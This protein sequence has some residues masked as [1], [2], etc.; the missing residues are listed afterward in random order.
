MDAAEQLLAQLTAEQRDKLLLAA[1]RRD[2]RVAAEAAAAV[3][4]GPPHLQLEST[5]AAFAE[6]PAP[7]LELIACYVIAATATSTST[8]PPPVGAAL[9]AARSLRGTCRAWRRSIETARTVTALDLGPTEAGALWWDP[10]Y[11]SATRTAQVQPV[12]PRVFPTAGMHLPSSVGAARDE[13]Q[14]ECAVRRVEGSGEVRLEVCGS[15]RHLPDPSNSQEPIA[16]Q[17]DLQSIVYPQIEV[18]DRGGG[19]SVWVRAGVSLDRGEIPWHSCVPYPWPD[20]ANVNP[21]PIYTLPLPQPEDLKV[22]FAALSHLSLVGLLLGRLP[23]ALRS[24]PS[25]RT[26]ELRGNL[27]RDLPSW[28]PEIELTTL[29]LSD[30]GLPASFLEAGGEGSGPAPTTDGHIAEMYEVCV[31]AV[32]KHSKEVST[33]DSSGPLPSASLRELRMSEMQGF[34]PFH[35]P[36]ERLT[37]LPWWLGE[38]TL[39]GSLMSLDLS[40]N[41]LDLRQQALPWHLPH[42]PLQAQPA[43]PWSGLRELSLRGVRT[44]SVPYWLS[45]LSLVSLDLRGLDLH[46]RGG[47]P[48]ALPPAESPAA[49][50]HA[51]GS[52]VVAGE[53]TAEATAAA[54]EV[55]AAARDDAIMGFMAHP[56]INDALAGINMSGDDD[57]NQAAQ[58]PG[59]CTLLR[60]I[61]RPPLS[62]SLERLDASIMMDDAEAIEQDVVGSMGEPEPAVLEVL[63]EC[64]LGE[65]SSADRGACRRL[66]WLRLSEWHS[67]AMDELLQGAARQTG[68][69]AAMA[70]APEWDGAAGCCSGVDEDDL[71]VWM[72]SAREVGSDVE[73]SYM[74]VGG[75]IGYRE[76]SR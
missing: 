48:I 53:M 74:A 19:G 7:A 27:L 26:L 70:P 38:K 21:R 40:D 14:I 68:T 2:S 59:L 63:G 32:I 76:Y 73:G 44:N 18:C 75:G 54:Y 42:S 57:L 41:Q 58:P 24:L 61:L 43:C 28:L 16:A 35:D 46:D 33:K 64:F 47:G 23:L 13:M 3:S 62:Q 72:E 15:C 34:D 25:L 50:Y 22:H 37:S 65:S 9:G 20:L 51:T 29:D 55:A 66:G 4:A 69:L 5:A 67:I 39:C 60:G 36:Y 56:S 1:M 31:A 11:G 52:G 12:P 8:R 10:T 49:V 6:L 71:R 45:A 17:L 30:S